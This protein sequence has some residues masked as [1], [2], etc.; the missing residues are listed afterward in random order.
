M[1]NWSHNKTSLYF[2]SEDD[3]NRFMD[4]CYVG[5]D[6][7]DYEHNTII[8]TN[9]MPMPAILEGTQAP[10]V[11]MDQVLNAKT[12]DE[13]SR[14]AGLYGRAAQ[15][16]KE[17]GYDNWYSWQVANWGTKWGV[18]D[19]TTSDAFRDDLYVN[20]SYATPWCSLSN[21]FFEFVSNKYNA[22]IVTGC[23][24]EGE[25]EMW[26]AHFA[27]GV[28]LKEVTGRWDSSG[29]FDEDTSTVDFELAM[30]RKDNLFDELWEAVLNV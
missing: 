29:L 21:E 9:A 26:A 30:E 16:K 7:H 8:L 15:A 19:V 17:T 5:D 23:D 13:R 1:P 27:A 14:L 11:T 4:D 25:E 2:I 6:T 10:P 12:D 22:V 3:Y 24:F 20:L 28:C 18:C